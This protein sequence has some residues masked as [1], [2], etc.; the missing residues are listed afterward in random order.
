NTR[1]GLP[2]EARDFPTAARMLELL[3]VGEIRLMTN[4]PA[5]VAALAA[6]GVSIA[7]RVPHAL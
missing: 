5:K 1:L 4:N 3:N 2:D 6:V 7:E